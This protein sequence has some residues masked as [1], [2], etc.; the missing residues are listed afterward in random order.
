MRDQHPS[1]QRTAFFLFALLGLACS[2]GSGDTEQVIPGATGKAGAGGTTGTAGGGGMPQAGAGGSTAGAGGTA[3]AGTGGSSTGGT[4]AAGAAGAAAGMAGTGTG[5]GGAAGASGAGGS[6]AGSAG[7]GTGGSGGM[8][9]GSKGCTGPNAENF[10]GHCYRRYS[11]ARTW[12]EARSACTEDGGYL[13][14]ISSQDRTQEQFD[15]EGDFVWQLANMEDVWIGT[16]DG[17]ADTENGENAMFTWV[18]G[19]AMTLEKWG[20]NEPNHYQKDCPNGDDCYEHCGFMSDELGGAW[21]DE[22]CAVE[23]AYVC[24]YDMPMP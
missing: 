12:G 10:E 8:D 1:S 15:A 20:D 7:S 14:V 4:A 13:V 3:T 5:G 9:G 16:S 21:N 2:S 22:I 23:M 11:M 24:E 6:A 17:R 19:E 18:N